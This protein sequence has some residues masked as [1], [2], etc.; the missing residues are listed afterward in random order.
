MANINKSRFV[1][2]VAWLLIM[3][4]SI[5]YIKYNL[6][7]VSDVKQFMPTDSTDRRLQVLLHETQK[8]IASNLILTQIGGASPEYL[9]KLSKN[10]KTSLKKNN[11]L[12]EFVSNGD[13]DWNINSFNAL[14]DYRYLL[15]EPDNFSVAGLRKAFEEL[16][17][18]FRSGASGEA[19]KY[20]LRDPQKTFVRYLLAQ[21][22]Q[23]QPEKFNNVWFV[24]DKSKA[25]LM[26]QLKSAGF[27]LDLQQAGI[28]A[29]KESVNALDDTGV[30]ELVLSG[31]GVIAVATRESIRSTTQEV[32]WILTCVVILLFW[33]GY[34]SIRLAFIA[35]IPLITSI[36]VAT[37]ITQMIF[38]EL[39][40]IVL[41]FGITM[42]GVCLDYPLHL[43]S[44]LNNHESSSVTLKRIWP[45][46]RLGVLTSVLAYVAL[47]G[48][49]FSGLTQLSVFSAAGLIVALAVTR[50]LIPVW[51]SGEWVNKR[52]IIILQPLST[53]IKIAVSVIV[54]VIP[55]F[56]LMIQEN[57]WST[58]ISQI[59]PVSSTARETDRE[60]RREL[61]ALDVTH[62]FLIEAATSDRVLADTEALVELIIPAIDKGFIS[63]V[64]SAIDISPNKDRQEYYQSLLPDETKLKKNVAKAM[65]GLG[66]KANAFDDFINEVTSSKLRP[67]IG[68]KT[69]L[70]S[71]LGLK[72]RTML[73]QQDNRWYSI[74]RVSGVN[75]EKSF[76]SWLK[77]SP[78]VEQHYVSMRAATNILMNSYLQS[79]WLRLLAALS[80]IVFVVLWQVRKRKE[81]IW[82]LVPIMA[83]V[84]V[85]LAVQVFLGSLINIFHV[86]SL[87]LVIGMGLDYSLFFNRDWQRKEQLI[88]RTHAIVI[89]AITT[90]IAFAT[91]GFSDI[92]VL[93]VM[94]QTV[95]I[96]I[97]TCFVVAHRIAIPKSSSE[98][99][100]SC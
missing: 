41:A 60:L 72:L 64:Q 91:L 21:S 38:G 96:G 59:S 40:G 98:V 67:S 9:S 23:A 63:G 58:E 45:T 2:T 17:T 7:V 82:L 76:Y 97:L 39:H 16:L 95:S 5:A 71:P 100:Q 1:V 6:S 65:N 50:W 31:P 37:A 22:G 12:F 79:A 44:H 18:A 78:S 8:G 52:S 57:I 46:L 35:G 15:K 89:S 86:L 27:D 25:L 81:A 55:L 26:I 90:I 19:V 87:L 80:L 85:S 20:L 13:Q 29:I 32:S 3:I 99:Q 92:P 93:K 74:V 43:F 10:L 53:K 30:I 94:G 70:A 51:V 61:H 66:F 68:Y 77:S 48:T 75:D 14:F 34:R 49:G 84:V 11:E 4:S 54:V 47:M 73:F 62:M 28:D 36:I 42:L 56:F 69:I 83:G 24:E 33:L 88:D